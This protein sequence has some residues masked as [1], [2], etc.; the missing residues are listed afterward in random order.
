MPT[1]PKYDLINF[2]RYNRDKVYHPIDQSNNYNQL[3]ESAKY[4]YANSG[5]NYAVVE[6]DTQEVVF[7]TGEW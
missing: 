2:T 5:N 7:E 6:H 4:M 3:L 1:N